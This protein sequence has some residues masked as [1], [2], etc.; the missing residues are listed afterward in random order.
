M[1]HVAELY[2]KHPGSDIYVVGTGASL[3]VFPIDFFAGRIVIG[4]NMAWKLVPV[5]YGITIHP[6][7]N[8]P[9][10]MPGEPPHPEI[11]WITGHRKAKAL[12]TASQFQHAEVNFYF[13]EYQGKPNTQS[14]EQPSDSGRNLDWVRNPTGDWMYVWSSIS[15][16]G[17]NLAAN[18]GARNVILVGCDNMALSGNHHAHAQH[19]R[20]KGVLPDERYR[21]YYEGLAEVR[22]ALRGRG[23]N[24]LS[25]TPFLSLDSPAADF[26]RLCR[27]RNVAQF[28]ENQDVSPVTPAGR[29]TGLFK[30]LVRR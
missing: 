2:G 28:I 20:W 23:V 3:R 26:E 27:E 17:A 15:Q 11:T 10:F 6:D 22:E 30:H 13:F 21:Q 9:E 1:H 25:L 14:P 5:T 8:I 12:L 7:L 29:L 16:T 4:L 24:V 19:T 18:L